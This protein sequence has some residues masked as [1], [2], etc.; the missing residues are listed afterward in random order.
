MVAAW[1]R[2]KEY[3]ILKSMNIVTHP[4]KPIIHLLPNLAIR[5]SSSE[6]LNLSLYQ[7]IRKFKKKINNQC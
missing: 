7:W 5:D 4:V 6:E 3:G 1:G 2:I